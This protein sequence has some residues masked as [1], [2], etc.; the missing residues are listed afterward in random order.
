MYTVGHTVRLCQR[1]Q[2]TWGVARR[3]PNAEPPPAAQVSARKL[4]GALPLGDNSADAAPSGDSAAAA[5]SGNTSPSAG[6]E[7]PAPDIEGA[8]SAGGVAVAA[9]AFGVLAFL[10][11]AWVWWR[12]RRRESPTPVTPRDLSCE[13][14]EVRPDDGNACVLTGTSLGDMGGFALEV[15]LTAGEAVPIVGEMCKYLLELKKRA[16]DCIDADAESRSL[17][18][19]IEL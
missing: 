11:G 6:G 18:V 7:T 8:S 5:P 17:S 15:L 3:R 13:L 14:P 9:G 12:Y 19:F 1:S 4:A 10:V 16:D 2:G